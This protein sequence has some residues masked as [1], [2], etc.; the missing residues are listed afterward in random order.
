MI[1]STQLLKHLKNG[2]AFINADTQRAEYKSILTAA[3]IIINELLLQESPEFYLDFLQR[4]VALHATG[5]TLADGLGKAPLGPVAIRDDLTLETRRAIV[6]GEIEKLYGNMLRLISVLNENNSDAERAWLVAAADWESSLYLHRLEQVPVNTHVS[7]MPISEAAMLAYLQ[8]KFPQWKKLKITSYVPLT[9]GFSKKTILVDT[10]DELNGNQ[11]IVVR[12]EQGINLF[13]FD[14]GDLAKEFHIIRLVR[15]HGVTVAEPLWM[16]TDTRHVGFRFMVSRRALG[17]TYGTHFGSEE[18]MSKEKSEAVVDAM[19]AELVALH[20]IKIDPNDADVQNSHL[21]SWLQYKTV[22]EATRYN[23]TDYLPR[24]VRL[25]DVPMTPLMQ[26][27]FNWLANNVPQVDEPPVITHRDFGFNNIIF[28]GSTLSAVLDWETSLLGDPA[29]DIAWTHHQNLS[30]YMS[31]PEFLVR[32]KAG[33][34][35][36]ISEFRLAYWRVINCM[37]GIMACLSS[38][39]ALETHDAP[40]INIAAMAYQ[41]VAAFGPQFNMLIEQAEQTRGK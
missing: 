32:Y 19:I 10:E 38:M 23:V 18:T 16:E 27:A 40:P 8:Q 12:A 9:G 7:E 39:R 26:R 30:P 22:T 33:S 4:G 35:R 14:G 25:T 13:Q 29:A 24:L 6:D 31:M 34:G 37:G 5:K 28:N 3:D 2:A 20:N 17:K 41:Y 21:N 36:D 15:K 1:S 11:A